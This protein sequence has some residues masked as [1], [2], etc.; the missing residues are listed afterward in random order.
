MRQVSKPPRTRFRTYTSFKALPES[1]AALFQ[2]AETRSFCLARWWFESLA[3]NILGPEQ[4]LSLI[5]L[6]DCGPPPEALALIVG[7]ES[8]SR[9]II[10]GE[11]R[12]FCGL[13]NYYSMI[14][15]P[16]VAE[17]ADPG[18]TLGALLR[19][20]AAQE[21]R[22]A[23]L[24]FQPLDPGSPLFKSLEAALRDAGFVVQPYFH[25][26]NWYEP[27]AGLTI[28][29]YLSRRSAALR[30]TIHRK[31][32]KLSKAG[33]HLKIFTDERE[34]ESGLA[35]YERIYARSWKMPE[36]YPQ[37]IRDLVRACAALGALRLGV[38]YLEGTPIAAQIWI[39]WAGEATLY[40]L[41]HDRDFNDLSPGTVLTYR[42][43]ERIVDMGGVAEIDFGVGDD[44]Y[45]RD[46]ASR[47]REK[48]G[49]MAFNPRS[50]HGILGALRHVG[51]QGIKQAASRVTWARHNP[52]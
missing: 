41:A 36:P 11:A 45:K 48:W 28:A 26:G 49:L 29:D 15:S 22:Y 19:A 10:I 20:M 8:N 2:Q 52:R 33:A 7:F 31:G 16:L 30:N 6:E 17:G 32:S 3:A 25:C 35:D 24:R 43:L 34:L 21:P 44:S 47:R 46:W 23:I 37:V 40:K 12:R 18:P 14:F 51:G 50:L 42:M 39:I 4:R 9:R 1:Y 5:G 27:L 38:L 13:S